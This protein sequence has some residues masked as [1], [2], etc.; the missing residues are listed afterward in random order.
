MTARRRNLDREA[1]ISGGVDHGMHGQRLICTP[2]GSFR[3]VWRFAHMTYLDRMSGNRYIPP[4]LELFTPNHR[5]LPSNLLELHN[6]QRTKR[7]S[8]AML[9]ATRVT[10][11]AVFGDDA[12]D[13][14]LDN[15]ITHTVVVVVTV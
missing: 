1:R 8:K 2:D 4:T 9:L 14:L 13:R 10:I 7:L 15:G 6:W 3:L 5:H 12:L 11:D